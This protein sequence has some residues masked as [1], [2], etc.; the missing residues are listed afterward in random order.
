MHYLHQTITATSV[1]YTLTAYENRCKR[2][3]R[4]Y[5]YLNLAQEL[6]KLVRVT[7]KKINEFFI[8]VP[9]ILKQ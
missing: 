9:N 8:F 6:R 5:K 4:L 1:F 3:N 7:K 2:L